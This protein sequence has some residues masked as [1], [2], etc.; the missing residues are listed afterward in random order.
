MKI[1]G[2][3]KMGE[4]DI[5]QANMEQLIFEAGSQAYCT[6]E[7]EGKITDIELIRAFT[8]LAVEKLTSA[9]FNKGGR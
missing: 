2:G 3:N 6:K 9:G 4:Q 5:E 1:K 8:K 7:N